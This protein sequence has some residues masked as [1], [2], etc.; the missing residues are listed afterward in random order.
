MISEL[1]IKLLRLKHRL[2]TKLK[3]AWG[4]NSKY[5]MIFRLSVK[6]AGPGSG[7][8]WTVEVR[9]RQ[10]GA[11]RLSQPSE[12]LSG[13]GAEPRLRTRQR[14]SAGGHAPSVRKD[15]PKTH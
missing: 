4:G 2:R 6:A 12:E 3:A 1:F 11:W 9:L 15:A 8:A 7:P 14:H 10:K 5:I 13:G